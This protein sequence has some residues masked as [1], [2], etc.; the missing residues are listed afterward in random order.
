MD[1]SG[2][3]KERGNN[4]KR[5]GRNGSTAERPAKRP[6]ES[7]KECAKCRSD[8][9]QTFIRCYLCD[10]KYCQKCCTLPEIVFRAYVTEGLE[11]IDWKCAPCQ[12]T[13]K[14]YRGISQKL[15]SMEENSRERMS[16]MDKKLEGMEQRITDKVIAEIPTMIQT[17]IEKMEGNV[18]KKM[19]QSVKEAEAKITEKMTEE[20][21]TVRDKLE[22]AKKDMLPKEEVNKMIQEALE[23]NREEMA[24]KLP[25]SPTS[26]V[27]PKPQVSPGT[28]LRSAVAEMKEREKRENRL[29]IYKLEEQPTR[30][31]TERVEKDKQKLIE[32]ASN[33]LAIKN[34]KTTEI[35]RAE[36]LGEKKDDNPRPLLIELTTIDRTHLIMNKANRLRD[37]EYKHISLTYDM[38][39]KEREQ[40][41]KLVTEA[42]K[43]QEAEGGRW[44]YKVRGPPWA[45]KIIKKEGRKEEPMTAEEGAVGPETSQDGERE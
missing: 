3:N 32:I 33:V 41:K 38:T 20:V 24:A 10:L 19:E 45:M 14:T 31:R 37:S 5:E 42:K 18:H 23:K 9:G 26:G 44:L 43:K 22:E 6:R 13:D 39:P 16:A 36:R 8:P 40:Q 2:K 21:K 29:V 12:V 35:I 34:L 7:E 4:S 30:L 27:A 1:K 11:G 25:N 28:L 15:D 17:E